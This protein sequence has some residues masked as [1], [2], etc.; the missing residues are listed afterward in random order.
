VLSSFIYDRLKQTDNQQNS[1][2]GLVLFFSFSAVDANRQSL[3]SLARTLLSQFLEHDQHGVLLPL[4]NSLMEKGPQSTSEMF[5]VL[6]KAAL[7]LKKPITSVIDGI[8]ECSDPVEDV[9]SRL[10]D[11]SHSQKNVG[12]IL[13][14][15]SHA[16]SKAL[17]STLD[18]R[19]ICITSELNR[20]DI[21]AVV[22]VN[23]ARCHSLST[24]KVRDA[25]STSLLAKA[26]GMFLWVRLMLD[27]LS[28]AACDDEILTRL[29]DLPHGLE[30]SYRL[31]LT[32]L[33]AR[34]DKHQQQ[35]VPALLSFA[36]VS[37]RP[38]EMEELRS[39]YALV[40]KPTSV[41]TTSV[42]TTSVQTTSSLERFILRLQPDDIINLCGGL[43]TF[44]GGSFRL[45]HNSARDYLTRPVEE[46]AE[47]DDQLRRIFRIDP[48][49]SH[50]VLG[51]A[52]LRYLAEVD[53]SQLQW[54]SVPS[55][56]VLGS[57]RPF[58]PYAC[59]FVAYHLNRSERTPSQVQEALLLLLDSDQCF[60]ALEYLFL[61]GINDTS[62]TMQV[63]IGM[64]LHTLSGEP[65]G[66]SK[67]MLIFKPR[68]EQEYLYR[69]SKFGESD[70]RTERWASY[71]DALLSFLSLDEASEYRTQI[72][73]NGIGTGQPHSSIIKNL[74]HG[75]EQSASSSV[76][77]D[78]IDAGLTS[79]DTAKNVQRENQV[80]IS[81]RM[82]LASDIPMERDVSRS[83]RNPDLV[84][85]SR[86]PQSVKTGVELHRF[87]Q[88]LPDSHIIPLGRQ[89][90]LSVKLFQHLATSRL[91][92]PLKTLWQLIKQKAS[93]LPVLHLV[94]V[95]WF[96]QG[97]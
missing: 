80:S 40:V 50:R 1:R 48:A 5:S 32:R 29:T 16:F 25:V 22:D 90:E 38:L 43:L 33:V 68:L 83:I 82:N 53:Y 66:F 26:D 11:L 97:M 23:L 77:D 15:R 81:R 35:L 96:F 86:L 63:E 60:F 79:D 57:E 41:Q 89:F 7:L 14:G 92:D 64:L 31:I 67:L 73:S 2:E 62:T 45:V 59:L 47:G 8:D 42:Q 88:S 65:D 28:T 44:S 18:A 56:D 10:L 76:T 84:H 21:R 93:S 74:R 39:T 17:K 91:L 36:A 20:D 61:L 85:S 78:A 37:G 58:L 55:L 13:L 75:S 6:R 49:V 71:H 12:F 4:F 69:I 19:S 94:A 95:G 70:P 24:S 3:D 54:E 51:D 27:Y 9:F 30:Q 72:A 52:C 46:W 87:I 34:L